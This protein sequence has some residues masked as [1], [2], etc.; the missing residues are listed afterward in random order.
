MRGNNNNPIS[1]FLLNVIDYQSGI[2]LI[3]LLVNSSK[4]KT[5]EPE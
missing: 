2:F 5:S 3:R 4:I 1:H